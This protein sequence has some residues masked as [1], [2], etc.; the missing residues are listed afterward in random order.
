M[1]PALKHTFGIVGF[2]TVGRLCFEILREKDTSIVAGIADPSAPPIVGV[3]VFENHSSLLKTDA[4]A[5]IVATPPSSHFEIAA[6]ALEAGKHVF[7]EKPP[8]RSVLLADKLG[9]L[10]AARR[11]TLFFG[12]H[13]RFNKSVELAAAELRSRRVQ[14]FRAVYKENVH[15]FHGDSHTNEWVLQEGVLRDSGINVLSIVTAILP[16]AHELQ[17]MDATVTLSPKWHAD[18]KA[19]VTLQT[20]SGVTGSI[21]LDWEH[22][23][24]EQRTV[25]VVTESGTVSIDISRDQLRIDNVPVEIPESRP[26]LRSEYTRMLACF[27][28]CIEAQESS[29]GTDEIRLV[30]CAREIAYARLPR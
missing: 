28:E 7:L 8:A 14:S 15:D 19:S 20:P 23:G 17:I 10:A 18:I 12:Y 16:C 3:P 30:E 27:I 13:A 4:E 22:P 6:A 1:V 25:E 26:G 2:G 11:R 24:P 9:Q 5:I 21:E 29:T